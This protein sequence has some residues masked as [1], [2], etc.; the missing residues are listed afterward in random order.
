MSLIQDALK[1][2]QEESESNHVPLKDAAVPYVPDS[3]PVSPRPEP[4]SRPL[5]VNRPLPVDQ[6]VPAVPPAM[7]GPEKPIQPGKSWRRIVGI[8][9]FCILILW[10]G[11]LL[12]TLVLDQSPLQALLGIF[13]PDLTNARAVPGKPAIQT[14]PPPAAAMHKPVAAPA[15]TPLSTLAPV[16][17]IS[18]AAASAPAF[19]DEQED[20]ENMALPLV[21][22]QVLP[23]AVPSPEPVV[24]P[25]LKLSAVFSNV[26]SGQ[27]GAR[28]N[29]RLILLGDQIEGVTLVEIRRDSVVLKCGQETRSLKMG[30]T[31]Y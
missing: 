24:W 19:G 1:R 20:R 13:M 25:Q 9:I 4:A 15:Q 22:I 28:L 11:G 27:A 29:N 5:L 6:P 23:V 14:P 2:Q 3:M 10:G 12:M 18:P 30:M 21:N 7:A 16:P 8:I 26:R 17:W 31:L